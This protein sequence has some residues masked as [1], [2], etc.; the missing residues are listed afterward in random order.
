ML[1]TRDGDTGRERVLV[2]PNERSLDHLISLDWW[3]PSWDGRLLAYGLSQSGSED[4]TLR[5]LDV[6]S[7]KDLPASEVITHA[8]YASV[9]WLP[10]GSGFY[11]S[12][13]PGKGTVKAGG[14]ISSPHFRAPHR[15]S[16]GPRCRSVRRGPS[17]DR[18]ADH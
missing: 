14:A 17:D 18:H 4:S 5:V 15:A 7:A 8:R 10:D 2:D 16:R 9:A 6:D 1:Y 3:A 12:R 13:Y 11:Y